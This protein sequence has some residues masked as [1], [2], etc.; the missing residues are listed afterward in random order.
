MYSTIE[1]IL[2]SF[3]PEVIIVKL[4]VRWPSGP[5]LLVGGPSGHLDFVLRALWALRPSD[6]RNSDWIVC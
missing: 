5:Q 4:E 1:R 2:R 6:L 3:V